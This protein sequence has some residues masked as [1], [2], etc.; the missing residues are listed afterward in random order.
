[1]G[2]ICTEFVAHWPAVWGQ[3]N[4]FER[5]REYM[6]QPISTQGLGFLLVLVIAA[7]TVW[8][9]LYWWEH[10]QQQNPR[11]TVI[12]SI[13]KNLCAVHGLSVTMVRQLEALATELKL[14]DPALLFV[15]PR[16]IEQRTADLSD[17]REFWQDLGT[18]LF[19]QHFQPAMTSDVPAGSPSETPHYD[20]A[21]TS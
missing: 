20:A 17:D 18:K 15:D 2:H 1:M 4:P 21:R 13:F 11:R 7:V 9:I 16:L 12:E 5:T 3:M 6:N 10:R 8:I 19:G 14:S